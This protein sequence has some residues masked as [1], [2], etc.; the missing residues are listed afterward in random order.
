MLAKATQ[1][2]DTL[3]NLV[4]YQWNMDIDYINSL[5]QQSIIVEQS[6]QLISVQSII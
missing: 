1:S 6:M 2:L 3:K 5:Q 4:K